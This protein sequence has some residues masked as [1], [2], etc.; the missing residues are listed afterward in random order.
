[1]ER[2][3]A[4]GGRRI[5]ERCSSDFFIIHNSSFIIPPSAFPLMLI[6]SP[7]NP[8][9]K[10]AVRLREARHRREQG[11]ILIDGVRELSRAIDAGVRMVEVFVCK[12]LCTT[13]ESQSLLEKLHQPSSPGKDFEI[14]EVTPGV[15]EKL[16]FGDRAE[17]ILG[18][19][20][21]PNKKLNDLTL[22]SPPAPTTS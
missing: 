18:V 10:N 3:K 1:M 9:V 8:R 16:A 5:N 15:F 4:E 6:T 14:L 22:P 13:P 19:A 21:M 2:G 20:E 17:G 7:Q 11:A 12:S